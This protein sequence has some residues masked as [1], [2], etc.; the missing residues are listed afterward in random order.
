[1]LSFAQLDLVL[2]QGVNA[3]IPIAI[4]PFVTPKKSVPQAHASSASGTDIAAIIAADL[5][6]SGRFRVMKPATI[7]Q[8]P[9]QTSA[10]DHHYWHQQGVDDLLIGQMTP[11]GQHRSRVTMN[12]LD[13]YGETTQQNTPFHALLKKTY[14]VNQH[15][16]RHLAHHISDQIYQK[17]MG[18][19]GNFNTRIAYVLVQ[20]P[21]QK[22]RRYLLEVADSDGF[23]PQPLVISSEPL[24]SPAWSSDGQKIAYV[25]F[26][27]H[28]A[29]IFVQTVATGKREIIA[30]YAGIN[31]APAWSHDGQ[32]MAVVLSKSGH[33]KLYLLDLT[34][35]VLTQLTQGF[36]IDT[37]PNWA[38]D[39]QSLIFTSNRGGSPQIYRLFLKNHRIERLT[40]QGKYNARGS[41]SG[42]GQHVAL[43]HKDKDQF[44][45]AVQDIKTGRMNVLTHSNHDESPNIAPNG[46]VVMYATLFLGHDVLGMVSTDGHVRLRLPSSKGNVREPAWS[47]SLSF[48]HPG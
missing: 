26:E 32:Q 9:H 21:H 4:V 14:T 44:S 20:N 1:M 34:T 27:H 25:S 28:R 10:V 37:E 39:D 33:P 23:N 40:Y 5:T 6:H 12:L 38:P 30:K 22:N 43:L 29:A 45:I 8:F 41:F 35:K 36:S 48:G 47:S 15:A 31:G 13:L 19:P 3:G 11:L 16:L 18:V 2:T 46:S 24:M 7:G 42:D 17:L